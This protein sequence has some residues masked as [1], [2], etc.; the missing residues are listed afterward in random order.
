[1]QTLIRPTWVLTLLLAGCAGR[2]LDQLE[3]STPAFTPAQLADLQRRAEPA[4]A[5]GIRLATRDGQVWVEAS[6]ALAHAGPVTVPLVEVPGNQPGEPGNDYRVPIVLATVN[7]RPGV[8]LMLDSGSNRVLLGYRLARALGVPVVAGLQPVEAS[9]I[10]GRVDN[11]L[12]VVK[13]LR[14]DTLQLRRLLALVGPDAQ[15]LGFAAGFGSRQQAVI[16]G[17]N[18]L[19]DLSFV[20]IDHLR[21]QATFAGAG[22]YG[23]D[24][25]LPTRL[26]VPLRWESDLPVIDVNVDGH[27]QRPCVLDTGGDYGMLIPRHL[28]QAFGY[29]R[30]GRG[31]IAASRGVAGASLTA[32]FVVR[33][34]QVGPMTF[35]G[36]PGRTDVS[37]PAP[38][39]A[40]LLLGNVVLRRHKV[41]FDFR[42]GL[43][44]LER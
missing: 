27:G 40:H 16:F 29:W 15:A 3:T 31:R 6:P 38:A 42:R 26:A 11:Y 43:L 2:P 20:S 17:V 14:V 5:L 33:R 12:A 13:E 25:G 30:P 28:A 24:A 18:A 23:A 37:G 41:T 1:M 34:V 7:D 8:A 21:G 39:R 10:G 36:V 22:E 35:Q 44:W 19:R 9:G 32:T 4:E